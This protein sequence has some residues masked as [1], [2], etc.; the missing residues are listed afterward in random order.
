MQSSRGD[1]L[2]LGEGQQAEATKLEE[3]EETSE[4]R[5]CEAERETM[6]VGEDQ[7]DEDEGEGEEEKDI[8]E[9]RIEGIYI[10]AFWAL[11][12]WLSRSCE[13]RRTKRRELR[14][15]ASALHVGGKRLFEK[16]A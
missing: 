12:I 1:G 14:S 13:V 5:H 2:L 3:E 6:E 7:W 9:G 11:A 4:D 15:S 10:C 16:G 8:A